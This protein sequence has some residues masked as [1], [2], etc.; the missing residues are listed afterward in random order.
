MWVI[1]Q[2]LSDH[3]KQSGWGKR[4]KHT[5]TKIFIF[6]EY[7]YVFCSLTDGHTEKNINRLD[8]EFY[9]K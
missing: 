7:I 6:Y 9:C 2:M 3:K 5:I 4:Y 8:L 1:E